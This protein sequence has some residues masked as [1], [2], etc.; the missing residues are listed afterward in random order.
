[1]KTTKSPI[2]KPSTKK[3]KEIL[4]NH[5]KRI[6]RARYIDKD[7]N[8]HCYTCGRLI[9]DP[10]K[11]HTGHFI[12]SSVCGAFLRYDLRNLR[13]QDYYCNINLGGNGAQ[14]YKNMVQEVGQACVDQLFIDKEKI[15][16]AT[17]HIL[18]LISEYEIM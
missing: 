9:D 15:V 2:K 10:A 13:V 8:W 17:D 7:G 11:A 5:C 12:A 4:W 18:Q 1:M 14:F 3:L 16:K 6:T